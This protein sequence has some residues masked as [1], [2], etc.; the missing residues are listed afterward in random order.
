[1]NSAP[2]FT[3]QS[4]KLLISSK[5]YAKDFHSHQQT[6]PYQSGKHEQRM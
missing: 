1:M 4:N 5:S 3:P 6:R 2:V